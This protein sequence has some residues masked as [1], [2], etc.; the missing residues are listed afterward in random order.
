MQASLAAS[1]REKIQA[2]VESP[3]GD[4]A[5]GCA[6]AIFREEASEFFFSGFADI[7]AGLRPDADTLY[8]AGS[9][10]KQ[11]TA[12]A[13]A[14]QV[15]AGRVCLDEDVRRYLPEMSARTAAITVGMLLHHTSGLPNYAK[16]GPL[17]GF[18]S[19]SQLRRA[20]VLRMLMDYPG[21]AFP[22]GATFEYSNG[23]YLLLSAIVERVSGEGFAQ[24]VRG[25]IL[26]PLGMSRTVV[27]DGVVPDDGNRAR[28]YMPDAGGF[29][30]SEDVPTF[31][32]AGAM[33]FTLN[34]FGRYFHDIQ[35][36]ACVWTPEVARLM[37]TP[38]VYADGSPIILPVPD[39]IFGYAGGLQLS[40]DWV[41]H[42]GNFAGFQAW[43]GW[44]PHSGVGMALLCN[45][46]DVDP[47][48]FAARIVAAVAPELPAPNAQRFALAGPGGRFVSD[49]LAAIYEIEARGEDELEVTITPPGGAAPAKLAFRRTADCVYA[50]GPISLVFDPDR[51]GFR[52]QNENVSVRYRRAT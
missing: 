36:G 40:R 13:L 37:T 22:P 38:G 7:A 30:L 8:Y 2:I 24:Y 23:G 5:P 46:G 27:L 28:G 14:Q 33:M 49:A 50:R 19:P 25:H 21:G 6:V 35:T 9:L 16:L 42:G 11:F 1:D 32:G 48:E 41:H 51:R 52:A 15:V 12:L 26:A 20:D 17:A 44:L 29:G 3:E 10:A 43:F 39:H 4:P 47:L 18:Q 45:R 31:G 34:D